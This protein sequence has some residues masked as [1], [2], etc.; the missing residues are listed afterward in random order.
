MWVESKGSWVR[1]VVA[2]GVVLPHIWRRTLTVTAISVVV[3][4]LYLRVPQAHVSI[5]NTPFVLIGLPLGIFLGFRN[6]AAYDRFWEGRKLWGQLVNTTRSLTRQ[7]LT[8]FEPQPDATET[9]PEAVRAWEH[10]VVH[11]VIAYVHALK[12][13][14]R[15]ESPF[16]RIEAVMGKAEGDLLRGADNVPY[17]ILQRLGEYVVEARRRKWIHAMHIPVIEQSLTILTDVQGACERIK[18]TPLP[19]SYTVLMHRIVAVYCTCL[20]FGLAETVGFVT[21]VVVLGVSYALFGLDAIGDEIEQPFGL[22]VND[23]PLESISR[24]IESNL[25][26]RI[27]EPQPEPLEAKNGVLS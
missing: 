17:A 8:L 27:G 6:S 2:G 14:L 26:V 3:T 19:Y 15:G 23:L 13:H 9:S 24:T 20:P 11:G 1:T 7:T 16:E 18:S 5:T 4:F 12:H 21:P 25:R 22:D 10:K